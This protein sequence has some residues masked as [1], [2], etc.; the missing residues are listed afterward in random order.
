M[1]CCTEGC[2]SELWHKQCIVTSQRHPC[3]FLNVDCASSGHVHGR[4]SSI[5]SPV[6]STPPCCRRKQHPP[7]SHHVGCKRR[8]GVRIYLFSN[9]RPIATAIDDTTADTDAHADLY[10]N[11]G[12]DRTANADADARS[13]NDGTNRT[14]DDGTNN[15]T[16][17]VICSNADADSRADRGTN[18]SSNCHHSQARS[19][20][21][22]CCSIH[23]LAIF[24]FLRVS[25]SVSP[26]LLPR[27]AVLILLVAFRRRR[28]RRKD[29]STAV[30]WVVLAA[31]VVIFLASAIVL[32]IPCCKSIEKGAAA[33]TT[34]EWLS[35]AP[36][37][38]LSDQDAADALDYDGWVTCTTTTEHGEFSYYL[39]Q[40]SGHTTWEWPPSQEDR[41]KARDLCKRT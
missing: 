39:H 25:F 18:V 27:T 29:S 37:I 23:K 31:F 12:T 22:P 41:A 11:N 34:E 8:I 7:P 20:F 10:T 21:T 15:G 13:D 1:C 33:S 32:A 26:C 3:T 40:P 14:A 19:I 5:R 36:T 38:T 17:G 30:L 16:N 35:L 24:P 9:S 28:K 2:V 6:W 4:A